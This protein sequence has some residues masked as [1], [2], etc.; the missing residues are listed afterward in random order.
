MWVRDVAACYTTGRRRTM[1][2]VPWDAVQSIN[3][4]HNCKVHALQPLMLYGIKS[5]RLVELKLNKWVLFKLDGGK[6]RTSGRNIKYRTSLKLSQVQYEC[7]GARVTRRSTVGGCVMVRGCVGGAA[8]A[9]G[10]VCQ[11][12]GWVWPVLGYLGTHQHCPHHM[13]RTSPGLYITPWQGDAGY[14][15]PVW[16]L[17][18]TLLAVNPVHQWS[19]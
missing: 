10:P 19:W 16:A 18:V 4:D 15:M 12:V 14:Y 7:W 6:S 1:L 9:L 2:V 11:P 8:S 5:S 13:T 3:T 17:S